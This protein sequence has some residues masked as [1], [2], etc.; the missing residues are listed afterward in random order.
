MNQS[1]SLCVRNSFIIKEKE[2]DEEES[3]FHYKYKLYYWNELPSLGYLALLPSSVS[4]LSPQL[5]MMRLETEEKLNRYRKL[6]LM[7]P[8]TRG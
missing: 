6:I 8:A 7:S 3:G 1:V 5:S 2:E 4:Q